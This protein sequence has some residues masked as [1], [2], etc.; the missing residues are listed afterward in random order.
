MTLS[1]K[2]RHGALASQVLVFAILLGVSTSR[3]QDSETGGPAPADTVKAARS[4]SDRLLEAELAEVATGDLAKA[5]ESYAAL[6]TDKTTPTE[7]GSLCCFDRSESTYRRDGKNDRYSAHGR[8][9]CSVSDRVSGST[10]FAPLTRM[11]P[12]FGEPQRAP[13]SSKELQ[14]APKSSEVSR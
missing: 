1:R 12:A 11:R 10:S 8:I 7:V 6:L 3:S 2:P 14:R 9:S 13:K 5:L 4:P